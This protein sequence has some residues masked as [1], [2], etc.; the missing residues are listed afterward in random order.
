MN[1]TILNSDHLWGAADMKTSALS[2]LQSASTRFR[3]ELEMLWV[4]LTYSP[5]LAKTAQFTSPKFTRARVYP[6]IPIMLHILSGPLLVLRYHARFAAQRVWPRPEL[7]DLVLFSVF[8]VSS[9]LLQA[10]RSK[11]PYSTPAIRTGFQ[12]AILIQTVVF[13]ASWV[14]GGD[15]TLFRAAVKFMNWFASFRMLER[16]LGKIDPRLAQMKLYAQK[17]ELTTIL[18]ACFAMWEAGIPGGVPIFLGLVAVFM[19]AERAV[20][21]TVSR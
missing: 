16:A 20:A 12:V 17:F 6:Y 10:Y 5:F 13:A 14:Q 21:E 18:S 15:A 7:I 3:P 1:S 9:F 11:T 19:I 4:I 8:S 2:S